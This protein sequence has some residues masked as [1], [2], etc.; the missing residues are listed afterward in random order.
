MPKMFVVPLDRSELAERA[1]PVAAALARRWDAQV[2]PLMV[3]TAGGRADAEH[4]LQSAAATLGPIAAAERLVT[5]DRPAEVILDAGR[6]LDSVVCMTTHGRGRLRWA[7][8][9]SVAEAVLGASENP[10]VLVGRRCPADWPGTASELQI[11]FD[12]TLGSEYVIDTA[13]EWARA[14]GCSVSIA[15]VIHPLDVVDPQRPEHDAGPAR[16]LV[17]ERGFDPRLDVIR[18]RDPAFALADLA[19]EHS[20]ALVAMTTSARA[21][22]SRLAL[23]SITMGVVGMAPCPLLVVRGFAD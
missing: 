8:L 11:C 1:L 3:T 10:V 20:A 18:S 15:R 12:G 9:G 6:D 4:Y 19:V 7:V 17:Q 21:G 5:S 23:G 13:C 16:D 2:L 22:V 14:L